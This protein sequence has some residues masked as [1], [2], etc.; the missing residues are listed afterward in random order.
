MKQL[1]HFLIVGLMVAVFTAAL[2]F[3]FETAPILP[4]AASR[5][6][7]PID[8]LFGFHFWIMAFLFSLIVGFM[9]YSIVAFRQKPGE[10]LDG[11]HIEGHT[12]LE[13]A[14]TV[15]PLVIVV[16][17]SFLGGQALSDT[18][19]ADPQAIRINVTARQWDWSFYYPEYDITTDVLALPLD[20][21]VL[22]RL[23]SED[24][25]HSFWVPEF[26]VKQD[27]LP[28][29]QV[30][31]LRI[32]PTEE[33]TYQLVC[34]ELCGTSHAY[35]VKDVLV[36]SPSEYDAWIQAAIAAD[37]SKSEDPV[38][39]GRHWVTINGCAGCH[40]TNGAQIVG[41]TW[42]GIYGRTETLTDGTSQVVDD[43]YIL[44]SIR[45]PSAKIVQGFNSPSVMPAYGPDKLTDEQIADIIE[46][47]KTLK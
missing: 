40:S 46:Y 29:D 42:K 22:L 14:W 41:P 27:L 38:V 19:R 4:Q 47:M 17:F 33:G 43:A 39:R 10:L 25:I 24:V 32:T 36:L 15:L 12:G 28:G 34:A 44:E 18:L 45:E 11:D 2:G 30:R 35:M 37:P 26:R 9:L 8:Q 16:A 7:E 21:Q 1:K 3:F 31:E 13:I 5:Q 6:A 23:R 20:Q